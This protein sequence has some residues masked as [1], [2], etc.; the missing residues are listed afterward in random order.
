MCIGAQGAI[1]V[2]PGKF[3]SIWG[4]DIYLHNGCLVASLHYVVDAK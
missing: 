4:R 2:G 3:F 1:D